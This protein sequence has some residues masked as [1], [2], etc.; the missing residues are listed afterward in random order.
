MANRVQAPSRSPVTTQCGAGPCLHTRQ[1]GLPLGQASRLRMTGLA[2]SL[3][4]PNSAPVPWPLK[5]VPW[6]LSPP[7]RQEQ[8]WQCGGGGRAPGSH[9]EGALHSP[10]WAKPLTPPAPW[11]LGG[12]ARLGR[13]LLSLAKGPP[14]SHSCRRGR[15][16]YW[17]QLSVG[18]ELSGTSLPASHRPEPGSQGHPAM[19][20]CILLSAA[21]GTPSAALQYTVG[22]RAGTAQPG[23]VL[24]SPLSSPLLSQSLSANTPPPS[25][26]PPEP[27]L[28]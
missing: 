28:S 21:P 17:Y 20:P 10:S 14:G 15:G 12:A 18:F 6:S 26:R 13:R 19:G 8:T 7:G 5:H 24:P 16:R 3:G 11:H 4:Q 23:R 1:P 2:A 9:A 25:L 22:P 27:G